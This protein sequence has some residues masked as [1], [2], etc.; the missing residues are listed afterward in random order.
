MPVHVSSEE[1]D[2]LL[3]IFMKDKECKAGKVSANHLSTILKEVD[4]VVFGTAFEQACL[5]HGIVDVR[6]FVAWICADDSRS[7]DYFE[8]KSVPVLPNNNEQDL[9][10]IDLSLEA[11]DAVFQQAKQKFDELDKDGN[12]V[13]DAFELREV[14][15]WVFTLF[16]RTFASKQE[17]KAAMH[18]QIQRFEKKLQGHKGCD[19]KGWDF[20]AFEAYFRGVIEDSERYQL[21]R[22]E[23][24]KN[25]YD[26]S[27]ASQKFKE[28]DK[29]GND[30]LE[31]DELL[32]FASWIHASFRPDGKQMTHEQCTD[33]ARKMIRRLDEK[34]GNGDGKLS[35]TEVDFYITEKIKEIESFQKGQA[36]KA[37]NTAKTAVEGQT[38][39]AL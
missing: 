11:A 18:K 23:A 31:G 24:Y 25:G 21:K 20:P 38:S 17:K 14:C 7:I 9:Q 26:K 1:S 29:N 8:A 32:E 4:A 37:A 39:T 3:Q 34:K 27:A 5:G 36:A 15:S 16:G 10:S 35:F 6:K 12:G 30:V 2:Q 22:Y 28:L 13:L 33:E 19:G